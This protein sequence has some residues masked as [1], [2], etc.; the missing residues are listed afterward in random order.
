MIGNTISRLCPYFSEWGL[1]GIPKQA[2]GTIDV[3]EHETDQEDDDGNQIKVKIAVY[4]CENSGKNSKMFFGRQ[5]DMI[6]KGA[7]QTKAYPHLPYHY[8]DLKC[9]YAILFKYKEFLFKME[10]VKYQDDKTTDLMLF[11]HPHKGIDESY[12]I[13]S[14][15]PSSK[16]TITQE[17]T[18]INKGDK[19]IKFLWDTGKVF[20]SDNLTGSD[21][22]AIMADKGG[23]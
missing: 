6:T 23:L 12:R 19:L 1:T 20:Y 17:L 2:Q 22:D 9:L 21:F 11:I 8:R 15:V 4:F 5:T 14:D 18:P 7:W 16:P 10:V 13:I 3:Y